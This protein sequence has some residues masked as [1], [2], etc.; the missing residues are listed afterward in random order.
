M[1]MRQ[2]NI[3]C[4]GILSDYCGRA[5]DWIN[6]GGLMAPSGVAKTYDEITHWDIFGPRALNLPHLKDAFAEFERSK[7][8]VSGMKPLPGAR[9]A[10]AI[11]RKYFDLM[12]VTSPSHKS[13][14]WVFERT[15]WLDDHFGITPDEIIYAKRKSRVSGDYLLDDSLDNCEKWVSVNKGRAFLWDAPYNRGKALPPHVKRVRAWDELY[16]E[17]GVYP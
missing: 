5:L 1:I 10:V 7:G 6:G 16:R 15:V 12:V 2:F 13:N 11:L 8:F 3:D 14:H 17:V 4:D 9:A